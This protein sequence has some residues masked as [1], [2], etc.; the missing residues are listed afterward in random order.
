MS[1]RINPGTIISGVVGLI[2][3]L[4]AVLSTIDTVV[5]QVAAVNTT[6][7]TF[8]GSAGAEALL[9]LVPFGYIAGVVLLGIGG[10]ITIFRVA[11]T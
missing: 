9:G 7:W 11:G 8:T 2:M 1:S 4:I 10:A 3:S 6:A 5:A